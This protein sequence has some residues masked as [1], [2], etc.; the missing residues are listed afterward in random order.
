MKQREGRMTHDSGG[1][2]PVFRSR[3][4]DDLPPCAR[5]TLSLRIV[6]A[7]GND[8]DV[9][10]HGPI[11]RLQGEVGAAILRLPFLQCGKEAGRYEHRWV[12]RPGALDRF[13]W[14]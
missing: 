4:D 1:D 6:V 10:V 14:A 11:P 7:H 12:N 9:D 3:V 13:V 2:A 5:R 8:I